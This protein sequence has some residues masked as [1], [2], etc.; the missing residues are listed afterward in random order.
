MHLVILFKNQYL[1]NLIK[2]VSMKLVIMVAILALIFFTTTHILH[3]L[4]TL[5]IAYE[6]IAGSIT[7]GLL[8]IFEILIHIR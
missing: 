2:G 6:I 3:K 7:I 8:L 4:N 1:N 5:P